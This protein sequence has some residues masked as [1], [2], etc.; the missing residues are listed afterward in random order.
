M[1]IIYMYKDET[2][3]I[4]NLVINYVC[5]R[6]SEGIVLLYKIGVKY[7]N[8]EVRDIIYLGTH[9]GIMIDFK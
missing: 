7:L 8:F 4:I 3:L 5:V 6:A 9:L 2:W 1:N